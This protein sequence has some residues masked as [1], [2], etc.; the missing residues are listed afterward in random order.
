MAPMNISLPPPTASKSVKVTV[1]QADLT[2]A[3]LTQ[4][5]NGFTVPQGHEIEKIT[6]V[7]TVL[8]V[9]GGLG[10]LKLSVGR[11]A[12]PVEFNDFGE[13]VELFGGTL[14]DPE[15]VLFN[16]TNKIMSWTADELIELLFTGDVNL[17][18]ITAFGLEIYFTFA[19]IKG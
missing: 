19:K 17:N 3:A 2:A 4:I 12:T 7:L 5:I 6:A 1:T 14:N 16:K 10:S 13:A 8:P 9:G 18:L 11:N 15:A